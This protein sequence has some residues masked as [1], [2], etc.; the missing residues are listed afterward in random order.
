MW[1]STT[2]YTLNALQFSEFWNVVG[3]KSEIICMLKSCIIH[4]LVDTDNGIC[5]SNW[6]F[7]IKL[8]SF[9]EILMK[10]R[11]IHSFA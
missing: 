5:S 11:L 3:I 9:S 4:L 2:L 7:M 10:V 6:Y 1:F 8:F